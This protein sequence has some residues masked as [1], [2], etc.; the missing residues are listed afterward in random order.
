MNN[1]KCRIP[2]V[3]MKSKGSA[4]SNHYFKQFLNGVLVHG[5]AFFTYLGHEAYGVDGSTNFQCESLLR[6]IVEL[7]KEAIGNGK[8]FPRKLFLQLDSASDNKNQ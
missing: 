3:L 6:T 4:S 5:R 2:R 7:N 1:A 8:P